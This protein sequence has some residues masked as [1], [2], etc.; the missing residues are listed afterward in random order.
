MAIR[1][2]LIFRQ[3]T[4]NKVNIGIISERLESEDKFWAETF[5]NDPLPE[6]GFP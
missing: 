3:E 1:G 2:A 6:Q 5:E 4:P